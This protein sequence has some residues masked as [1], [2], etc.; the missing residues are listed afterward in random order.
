M[1]IDYDLLHLL[2]RD[3]FTPGPV[4]SSWPSWAHKHDTAGAAGLVRLVSSQVIIGYGYVYVVRTC[5]HI[6]P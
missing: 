5:I 4:S 3:A 1:K 2:G 6:E